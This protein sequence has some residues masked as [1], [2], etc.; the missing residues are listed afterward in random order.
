[1][2]T[3]TTP[4]S[5]HEKIILLASLTRILELKQKFLNEDVDAFKDQLSKALQT[6][7]LLKPAEREKKS[8]RRRSPSNFRIRKKVKKG[9]KVQPTDPQEEFRDFSE[10]LS[11]IPLQEP[12]LPKNSIHSHMN[13]GSRDEI[14][15]QGS[16]HTRR[17]TRRSLNIQDDGIL[18]K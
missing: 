11:N 2:Q 9:V 5:K 8:V 12:I 18:E 14:S 16:E 13:V 1:M 10:K 4:L 15:L 17:E 7:H 3:L 6:L